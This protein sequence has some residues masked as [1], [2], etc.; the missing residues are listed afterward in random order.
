[1]SRFLTKPVLP[2]FTDEEGNPGLPGEPI[3]KTT[4]LALGD[5]ER[6]L[7]GMR[8]SELAISLTEYI[9]RLIRQDAD[10]AGLTRYLDE[11]ATRK[12]VG[13]GR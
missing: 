11:E 5:R 2:A 8:A 10:V 1:L 6:A 7:A 9:T 12:G 13:H 4:H 3:M